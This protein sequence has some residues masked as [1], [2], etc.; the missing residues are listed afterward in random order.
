MRIISL[1]EVLWDV[2]SE[3]EFLGGAPLN[4]SVSAQR[5]GDEVALISAVG[6]DR[7][8][9]LALE[10]VR[11][12]GPETDWI[13]TLPGEP[14]G[15][16]TAKM[17]ETG[18]AHFH[19]QRPVA[20]DLLDLNDAALQQLAAMQPGWIYFGTLAQTSAGNEALLRRL[21]TAAP[22]ARRFYDMNLREGQWSVELLQR[23]SD[24]ATVLKLNESEAEVL[25]GF[26]GMP[27]EFSCERFCREWS[28][29]YGLDLICITLGE[30]GCAVW[31]GGA[32]QEFPGVAVNVVDTVGAGD[33]FSAAFLHGIERGW[34][35]R[36]IAGFAN[37]LGALVSSRAGAIPAWTVD[38]LKSLSPEAFCDT[39]GNL[40]QP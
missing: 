39:D 34:P 27:G 11:A 30:R 8:G 32:L 17:D 14:T 1:G 25:F 18:S 35:M 28:R 33:A 10:A 21:I 36:R 20:Y 38:E 26:L 7:R 31:S 5:L 37:S 40:L 15:T 24:L 13:R 29:R 22:G 16:A 3:R 2:I 12:L 19:I 9:R 6:D 23:L 4:F